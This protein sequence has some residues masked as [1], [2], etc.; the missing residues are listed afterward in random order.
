GRQRGRVV[1]VWRISAAG[2]IRTRFSEEGGEL[3]EK[4]SEKGSDAFVYNADQGSGN[5][6]GQQAIFQRGNAVFF[7]QE[8]ADGCIHDGG[9]LL[10][11]KYDTFPWNDPPA[12]R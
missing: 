1:A 9:L 3:C 8:I 2:G 11:V 12:P 6:S 4:R 7:F 10:P 5:N